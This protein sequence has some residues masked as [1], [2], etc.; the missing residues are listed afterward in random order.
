MLKFGIIPELVGRLPVIAPLNGLRREDLVRILQEPKNAL[1]KQYK[2]L[3]DLDRVDLEFTDD[4]LVT[5]AK[6]TLERKTGARGLRAILEDLLM[7]IMYQVPSDYTVEKVVITKDMVE[8]NSGPE[9]VYNKERKPMKIRITTP[10][11]K[12][13]RDSAS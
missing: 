4:A 9:I 3:F 5:V 2:K 10:K 7:P 12:E 13:R 1:V 6:K 8:N 11:R